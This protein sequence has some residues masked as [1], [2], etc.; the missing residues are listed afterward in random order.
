MYILMLSFY[1]IS[2]PIFAGTECIVY[3]VSPTLASTLVCLLHVPM[4]LCFPPVSI[5]IVLIHYSWSRVLGYR[6]P[7]GRYCII[8]FTVSRES[9]MV[10]EHAQQTLLNEYLNSQKAQ[11]AK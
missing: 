7:E 11:T 10:V 2:Q 4:H 5:C 6:L 3:G 8:Y 9:S 1:K